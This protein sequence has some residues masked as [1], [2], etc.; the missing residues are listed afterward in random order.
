MSADAAAEHG[1]HPGAHRPTEH[2]QRRRRL[3]RGLA[4]LT[5]GA[6][7]VVF[8]DIGTSPLYAFQ[9]VFSEHHHA[10]KPTV[11]DVLG[12]VSLVVW[13]LT[14][15]VAVKFVT[16]IMKADNDGEGGILALTAL[17]RRTGELPQRWKSVLV[18]LGLAG[19]SLFYG[20]ALLTPAISVLSAVEGIE[21]TAPGLHSIIMPI[22][23]GLLIGLFLIQRR[24]THAIG[25]LF[26][27]VLALWFAA[28]GITGLAQIA[29]D[30]GILRALSPTYAID[31]WLRHP[32]TAFL[33]LGA[34]VLTV[35]GAEA[36]YA[37][38]GHF[39]RRPIALAWYLIVFPALVLNYLGQ[40]SLVMG[41]PSAIAN[42]FYRLFPDPV[43][44]PMIVLATA[45]TLIASQA[46][47][48]GAFSVSR[49][50][51]QLG[52]L[53][54]LEIRHTSAREIGQ[55]YVPSVNW[56]LMIAVALLVLTFEASAKLTVAYGVAV[57]GTLAIDS[58]LFLV[59][60]RTAWRVK[61]I[62]IAVGLVAFFGFDIAFLAANTPKILSDGWIPLLVGTVVFILLTSWDEGRRYLAERRRSTE[63][64]LPEFALW[65]SHHPGRIRRVP[66]TGIFLNAH[67]GTVP[68]ALRA[69]VSH[70]HALPET[71]V[72][73]TVK[74]APAPFVA[75][76]ERLVLDDVG[77]PDDGIWYLQ[78]NHGF[79]EAPRVTDALVRHEAELR[80]AGLPLKPYV[81]S[82]Y[83]SSTTITA[84]GHGW[85]NLHRRLFAIMARNASSAGDYL[86]LPADCVVVV[87]AHAAI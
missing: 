19:V 16:F 32:L 57:S 24:G 58:L 54:R 10:I 75:E 26:G 72:V 78:L 61:R 21:L 5:L 40:A 2:E 20:D 64:P 62:W 39:G 38:M 69:T 47:I 71:V 35:T 18:L 50:A 80:A 87:G 52:F 74:V 68:Y 44:I 4:V 17:I 63:Q 84:T 3:D 45:A 25:R 41:D 56:V 60:A 11:D 85:R 28:I 15:I 33:S 83:L 37:D 23:L 86:G 43:L 79:L 12:V 14:M 73:L 27:P 30:P 70:L 66:G 8:G 6:L 59:L 34:V 81:A 46:V 29:G 82:Y 36:L 7:G 51:V 22:A 49:Q 48:S 55:V 53:P 9:A 76:T 67:A 77:I 31:F 1:E 13:T 42:P 65:V